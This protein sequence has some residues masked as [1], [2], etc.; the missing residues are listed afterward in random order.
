MMKKLPLPLSL[1]LVTLFLLASCTERAQM[2]NKAFEGK[3]IQKITIHTKGLTQLSGKNEDDSSAKPN[4]DGMRGALGSLALKADVTMYVKPDKLAYEV[5]I[6]GGLFTIRTIVDPITRKITLLSPDKKAYVGDL[7]KF[8]AASKVISDSMKGKGLMDSLFT[9]M[10]KPSGKKKEIN[11]FD[12]EQYLLTSKRN[13]KK[14]EIE[15][16]ITSDPRLKFY[17][18][19]RDAFLGKRRTGEGGLEEMMAAFQPIAGQGK[20]PVTMTMKI[21]GE[22]FLSSELEEMIEEKLDNKYFE[23]PQGYEVVQGDM[24]KPK[25][26]T[27]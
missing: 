8:D 18:V 22:D 5:S 9:I 26:D 12:C 25:R 4:A 15:M 14:I 10:P 21:D 20:V 27:L 3:I 11:G 19:I 23:I 13:G 24:L 1:S 17:D 7:K 6:L 2:P 16:W